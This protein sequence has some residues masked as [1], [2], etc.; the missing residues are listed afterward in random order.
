MIDS[1][2]EILSEL[3]HEDIVE[4]YPTTLDVRI[5]DEHGAFLLNDACILSQIENVK[6]FIS[7]GADINKASSFGSP[8]LNAIDSKNIGIVAFLISL[9]ADVNMRDDC[10]CTPLLKS[11]ERDSSEIIS[12]LISAGADLEGRGYM[13][14][15]PFLKACSGSSLNTIKLLVEKGCDIY[16]TY[17]DYGETFTAFEDAKTIEVKKYLVE[18][19]IDA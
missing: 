4:I 14:Q 11:V 10:G 15:T 13:D 8:L 1:Y 9:G 18:L 19:G 16:A 3:T 7:K 6:F 2:F 5:P 12:L 17:S